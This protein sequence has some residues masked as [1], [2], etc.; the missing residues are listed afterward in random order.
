MRAAPASKASSDHCIA[1]LHTDV[2]GDVVEE[3]LIELVEPRL[4]L[5]KIR[6]HLSCASGLGVRSS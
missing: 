2:L 5:D 3:S 4:V 6:V 1:S